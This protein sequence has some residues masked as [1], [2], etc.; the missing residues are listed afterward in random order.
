M[1][2]G[3][4]F[5]GTLSNPGGGDLFF[6]TNLRTGEDA[7]EGWREFGVVGG[8]FLRPSF[9]DDDAFGGER[10]TLRTRREDPHPALDGS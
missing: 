4:D 1:L 9:K 2:I 10:E 7:V 6:E 5:D 8:G 3:S